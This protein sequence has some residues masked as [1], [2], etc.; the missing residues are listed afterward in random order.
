MT[1]RF[2]RRPR[3]RLKEERKNDEHPWRDECAVCGYAFRP[4]NQ[5]RDWA[6]PVGGFLEDLCHPCAAWFRREFGARAS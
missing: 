2:W 5:G 3:V 4:K 1:L 6:G